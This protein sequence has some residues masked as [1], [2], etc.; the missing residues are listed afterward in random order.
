M[1][2][3][4]D[5]PPIIYRCSG[6]SLGIPLNDSV[7]IECSYHETGVFALWEC[8]KSKLTTV[9]VPSAC[10]IDA[11]LPSL[12]LDYRPGPGRPSRKQSHRC[13][14]LDKVSTDEE[15]F[16]V[17]V[18]EVLLL[19]SR[20]KDYCRYHIDQYSYWERRCWLYFQPLRLFH[21]NVIMSATSRSNELKKKSYAPGQPG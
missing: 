2:R 18:Y 6:S 19:G 11:T 9:A 3:L 21:R 20:K 4:D 13:N 16:V 5:D 12:V 10:D 17:S 14:F 1:S 8:G 15:L 7:P